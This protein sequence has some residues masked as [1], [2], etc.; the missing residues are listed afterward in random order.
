MRQPPHNDHFP[1]AEFET[2]LARIRAEMG[3]AGMHALLLSTEAN[4]RYF[5]GLLSGYWGITLHDDVQLA[6]ISRDPEVEPVLLLP[7][8]LQA[9]AETTGCV[10]EFRLWSQFSGGRSKQPVDVVADTFRDLKLARGR[11]GIETGRD[12]RPGMSIPFLQAM[13]SRLP[14]VEWVDCAAA[15]ARLR[16]VKSALE[17]QKIRAAVDITVQAFKAGMDALREGMSEKELA[18]ILALEMARLSPD[19]CVSNPW[20]LFVTTD[21]RSPTAYD[22]VPTSY[23]FQPGDCIQL[24]GGFIFQGYGADLCR[25][26]AIGDPGREKRRYYDAALEANLDT[27]RQIRPGL[28][29]RELYDFWEERVCALG[30]ERSIKLQ[31]QADIDFLGHGIGLTTHELPVLDST[32]ETVLVPGMAL[33][34]EGDIVDDLPYPRRQI[35]V[36]DEEDVLVTE[37]G[38]EWLSS[39][40]PNELHIV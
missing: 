6:L 35:S 26:L 31:R 37:T 11:V 2:R 19:V 15:L 38:Y 7:D 17:T 3:A 27:M 28:Q 14:G 33:A 9:T 34:I 25:T 10:T 8:H 18:Q 4:V 21:G 20:I 22:G 40:L 13:Q 39:D 12:D 16:M 5:T 24:D 36:I 1:L 32:T 30:F 29:A 23:R